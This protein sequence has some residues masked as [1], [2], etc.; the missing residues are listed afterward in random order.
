MR[1]IVAADDSNEKMSLIDA[2]KRKRVCTHVDEA[3]FANVVDGVIRVQPDL[4]IIGLRNERI[5]EYHALVREVREIAIGRV[6]VVGPTVEAKAVLKF[7]QEGA[8]QYIDQADF[9]NDF[10]TVLARIRSEP[11]PTVGQ[12]RSIVVASA[13]GGCGASTLA[14]N[15]ATALMHKH[16]PVALMDLNLESGDLATLLNLKP[17][18][19]ISDFCRNISRMDQS[20]FENCMVPHPSG[21]Q[22]LAAPPSLEQIR[23]IT[24]RGIRRLI[25]MT[26][27]KFPY[28]V[29][30]VG[31]PFRQEHALALQQAESIVLTLRPE[32]CS[33]NHASRVIDFLS[34]ANV[35]TAKVKAVVNR[36][37]RRVGVS[38]ADVETAL[39]MKVSEVLPDDPRCV[40]VC[41]DRGVPVVTHKPRSSVAKR[42]CALSH[43]LN[44]ALPKL[45]SQVSVK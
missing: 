21:L 2:L 13:G 22:V 16:G 43:S 18:H 4:I 40:S 12:G 39:G 23:H 5:P 9:E 26:R 33:L 7:L 27:M 15:L 45:D 41:N 17:K 6:V 1:V 34:K 14:V 24:L 29:I 19:S 44:G 10:E 37:R 30:D 25:H 8:F 38:L 32:F 35:P 28:V 11:P 31:F 20:M 36:Y 3:D 42:L